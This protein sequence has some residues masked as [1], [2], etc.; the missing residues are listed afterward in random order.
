MLNLRLYLGDSFEILKAKQEKWKGKFRNVF[1][2]P[3]YFISNEARKIVKRPHQPDL[4]INKGVRMYKG[5]WDN[6]PTDFKTIY[7][8]NYR[9]LKLIKPLITKDGTVWVCGFWNYNLIA[10]RL[11][12]EELGYSHLNN[13]TIYKPNAVPNLRGVR[14]ATATE[15]MLWAKPYVKRYF[16]YHRM[17]KYN[18]GKQMRDLWE[19]PVDTRQN[20]GKHSTQKSYEQVNRCIL[21]TTDEKDWVLDPFAGSCTTMKVCKDL[22]RNCVCIEKGWYTFDEEI[23]RFKCTCGKLFKKKRELIEHHLAT[24]HVREFLR[25]IEIKVGWGNASIDSYAKGYF[26]KSKKTDREINY[27]KISKYF[28]DD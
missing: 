11:A 22:N 26:D 8:W 25:D 14:F 7:D 13:I 5:D 28:R 3:P 23:K 27:K 4:A 10:V 21:A 18:N 19:I 17:K 1:S 20:V 9:W 6:Q 12:M 24:G 2:D 16:A 15:N